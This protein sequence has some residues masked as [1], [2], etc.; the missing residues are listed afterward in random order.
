MKISVM[1]WLQSN[2][3]LNCTKPSYEAA[4]MSAILLTMIDGYAWSEYFITFLILVIKIV[5]VIKKFL[6]TLK[7]NKTFPF[8]RIMHPCHLLSFKLAQF[9]FLY[10]DGSFMI[11]IGTLY[12]KTYP[13]FSG[14]FWYM[15]HWWIIKIKKLH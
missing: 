8:Y 14:K 5:N 6:T 15:S 7:V 13:K 2:G 12:I 9:L 1:P 4:A 10:F 3:R 11:H